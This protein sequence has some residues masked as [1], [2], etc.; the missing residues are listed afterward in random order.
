MPEI[1]T[2]TDRLKKYRSYKKYRN[3]EFERICG[4]S[5]GYLN[6]TSNPGSK[7][8]EQILVACSDLNRDW[9]LLGK[10]EMIIEEPFH[11][12]VADINKG[13]ELT[14]LIK[15]TKKNKEMGNTI[16][17]LEAK[18]EDLKR[19][20]EDKDQIIHMLLNNNR[21]GEMEERKKGSAI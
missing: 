5:N 7:L 19:Q 12:I 16:R 4:L 21:G 9:V 8:L 2:I 1:E 14:D 20:N 17:E 10:G 15:L 18:I 6:S 13:I 3:K 11:D